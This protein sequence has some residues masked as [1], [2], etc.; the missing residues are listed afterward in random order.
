MH[1]LWPRAT[2]VRAPTRH[3]RTLCLHLFF[4]PDRF[5]SRC[6]SNL[7]AKDMRIAHPS[8]AA[9]QMCAASIAVIPRHARRMRHLASQ[10]QLDV[11]YSSSG[12]LLSSFVS[13]LPLSMPAFPLLLAFCHRTTPRWLSSTLRPL[14]H[15]RIQLT[16]PVN[17]AAWAP[18]RQYRPHILS[19]PSLPLRVYSTRW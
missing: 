16:S 15:S 2:S 3:S 11:A 4:L 14:S 1:A 13:G 12:T 19:F 7:V 17:V 6:A 10:A 18:C 9:P 5:L 8:P